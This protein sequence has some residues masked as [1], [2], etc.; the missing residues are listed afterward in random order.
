[1]KIRGTRIIL[2]KSFETIPG[3]GPERVV[4]SGAVDTHSFAANQHLSVLEISEISVSRGHL[5]IKVLIISIWHSIVS[6]P[7]ARKIL[8]ALE[9]GD[10][11]EMYF[12]FR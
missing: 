4:A 6:A 12:I 10:F 3:P 7:S 11:P 9:V 1:M 8:H 2:I 5:E